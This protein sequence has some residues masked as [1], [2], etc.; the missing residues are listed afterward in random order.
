MAS[1]LIEA[2]YEYAREAGVTHLYVHVAVDNE[3]AL[4]LY[5]DQCQFEHEQTEDISV[6]KSLNR[7]KRLLLK[8]GVIE[9]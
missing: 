5:R 3:S 2:A 7:P 8:K 9:D 1:A 6:A 4:T